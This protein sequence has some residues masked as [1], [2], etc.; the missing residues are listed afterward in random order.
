MKKRHY[1][2]ILAVLGIGGFVGFI[3]QESGSAE[4][5]VLNPST[6]MVEVDWSALNRGNVNTQ[7]DLGGGITSYSP[8]RYAVE[9][10]RPDMVKRCIELGAD[11]NARHS[12]EYY[13]PHQLTP[14]HAAIKN[15][16]TEIVRLLV[17]GGADLESRIRRDGQYMVAGYTP[18]MWA[19][20]NGRTEVARY[21]LEQGA[22]PAALSAPWWLVESGES[23]KSVSQL[24]LAHADCYEV[25][26]EYV[27]K[28]QLHRLLQPSFEWGT[29]SLPLPESEKSVRLYTSPDAVDAVTVPAATLLRYLNSCYVVLKISEVTDS[30][31]AYDKHR[32]FT[33]E[34]V[35]Y[36]KEPQE[37][38]SLV[39]MYL[40]RCE[41][42][43]V[44][45]YDAPR[46]EEKTRPV[47]DA[48]L[49]LKKE[50]FIRLDDRLYMNFHEA[51]DDMWYLSGE[52]VTRLL[53]L[54]GN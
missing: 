38:V 10:N 17:Q 42:P 36:G 49:C 40:G 13:G 1:F 12:V 5:L 45:P 46:T 39:I 34:R 41:T 11:V 23:E 14:L 44:G 18:L 4:V 33:I 27:L 28:T 21:L 20:E 19:V 35:M 51:W 54:M 50:A 52:D 9:Q 3:T 47:Q 31:G 48:Y 24:A 15:G 32:F 22:D 30:V 16:N 43:V 25:V 8:L 53:Q 6:R 37:P 7:L 2:Y 26:R 29:F